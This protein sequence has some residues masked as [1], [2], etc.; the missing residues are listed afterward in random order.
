MAVGCAVRTLLSYV[1]E[2]VDF[3]SGV[4]ADEDRSIRRLG[5]IGRSTDDGV[6]ILQEIDHFLFTVGMA[7]FKQDS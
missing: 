1:A 5:A 2:S 7:V 3:V 6:S 4:V